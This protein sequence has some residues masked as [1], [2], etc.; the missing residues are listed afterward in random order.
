[1][2]S[3]IFGL[4]NVSISRHEPTFGRLNGVA[5]ILMLMYLASS[6]IG[7]GS[8]PDPTEVCF[9]VDDN[10]LGLSS[11]KV[12][13]QEW[14]LKDDGSSSLDR[15]SEGMATAT[16]QR[17]IEGDEVFYGFWSRNGHRKHTFAEMYEWKYGKK[18]NPIE[19]AAITDG[20]ARQW[21][22]DRYTTENLVTTE[23]PQNVQTRTESSAKACYA[24][25]RGQ[26]GNIYAFV[27]LIG[28][29][30]FPNGTACELD[31]G[32]WDANAD[33]GT[34]PNVRAVKVRRPCAACN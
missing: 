9:V 27:N 26:P 7:C 34:N 29:V 6:M 1:M 17:Y 16:S 11:A 19:E 33:P 3:P 22:D 4:A 5:I 10:C 14:V 15:V 24:Y 18:P 30:K 28:Y 8:G 12:V 20:E 21:F 25:T 2:Y 13:I 32:D 31:L 23:H